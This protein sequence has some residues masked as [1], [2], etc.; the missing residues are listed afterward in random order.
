MPKEDADAAAYWIL[1]AVQQ[2][3]LPRGERLPVRRAVTHAECTQSG[4][5]WGLNYE[6]HL[7]A[8]A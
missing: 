8:D 3:R 7:I 6:L 5:K 2:I 1:D 4:S